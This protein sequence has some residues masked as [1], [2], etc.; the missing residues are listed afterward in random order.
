VRREKAS[1]EVV[2]HL[3][4]SILDGRLR[5]GDRLDIAEIAATLDVSRIPVREALIQLERDGLVTSRFHRGVFMAP[6]D[7]DTVRE[8]Y[9]LYGM[10]TGLASAHAAHQGNPDTVARLRRVYGELRATP[11]ADGGRWEGLAREFRR[12]VH[13]A[14]AGTRL[15]AMLRTFGGFIPKS[16]RLIVPDAYDAVVRG[17][18]AELRALSAGDADAARRCTEQLLRELGERV[19]ATMVARGTLSGAR[20]ARRAEVNVVDVVR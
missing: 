5:T 14:G 18:R 9:E 12:V 2:D 16:F 10:L 8:Q 7:A 13:R 20:R 1:E 11:A 6:F 3:L 19:V 15:L 17:E 4:D